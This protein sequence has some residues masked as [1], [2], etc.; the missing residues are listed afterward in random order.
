LPRSPGKTVDSSPE[1]VARPATDPTRQT[2][3]RRPRHFPA[4]AELRLPEAEAAATALADRLARRFQAER[5]AGA[6]RDAAELAQWM[7]RR[8]DALCGPLEPRL[9]DL[10]VT[11][12]PA[13]DWRSE[14]DPARRLG[15]F[16][17]DP[18]TPADRRRAANDILGLVRDRARRD[19]G[20][21]AFGSP[22]LR[23]I[24]LL[25]AT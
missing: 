9:A 2:S 4:W 19:A 13:L 15:L 18:A 14:P 25:L 21:L 16:S 11:E 20:Q 1:P 24:G 12:G 8:A 7:R 5:R 23:P 22:V 3:P 17:A 10:F 6:E